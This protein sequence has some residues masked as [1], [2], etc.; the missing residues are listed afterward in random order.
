MGGA[1]L[2]VTL[3]LL[4]AANKRVQNVELCEV[5]FGIND[6]GLGKLDYRLSWDNRV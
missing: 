6:D 1:P 3:I 4:L 2:K 5:F